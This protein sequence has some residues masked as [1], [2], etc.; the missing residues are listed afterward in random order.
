MRP[1]ISR[2][3]AC[4]MIASF[5]V[6]TDDSASSSTRI[7]ES[8]SSAR[9]IASRWRWPPDKLRAALADHGLVAVRQGA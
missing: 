4:W 3:S 2:S 9:A 7:G 6:S 1:V 8:R 5:S